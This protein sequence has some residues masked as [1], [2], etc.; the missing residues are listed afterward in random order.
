MKTIFSS[1]FQFLIVH[2]I[3]A[4]MVHVWGNKNMG[5]MFGLYNSIK[6]FLLGKT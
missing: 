1:Q 3:F 5:F 2:C 4:M 6:L